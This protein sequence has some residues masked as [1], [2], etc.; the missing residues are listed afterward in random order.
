MVLILKTVL[1][2]QYSKSRCLVLC[3]LYR[4]LEYSVGLAGSKGYFAQFKHFKF[5]GQRRTRPLL[6]DDSSYSILK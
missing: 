6:W 4:Y 5:Q 3:Y 2:F 1:N